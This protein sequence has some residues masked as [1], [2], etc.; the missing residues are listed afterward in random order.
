MKK[1][2]IILASAPGARLANQLW[3]FISIYA[4][5]LAKGYQCQNFS[6]FEE[7]KHKGEKIFNSFFDYG[8]Y[9]NIPLKN[10]F[11]KILLFFHLKN[12]KL[13]RKIRPYHRYVKIIKILHPEKIIYSGDSPFYLPPSENKNQEQAEK[14]KKLELSQDKKI[15]FSGWFLRNP[16]GLAEYRKEIVSY[17]QPKKETQE[18]IAAL[19]DKLKSQY[20]HLVGVHIRQSDYK[21]EFYDGKLYFK[22]KEINIFLKE[23][24]DNFKID[25]GKTCFIICSDENVNLNYFT[26]LNIIKSNFNAVEDLFLL[27]ATDIIIGSDSTFGAFASYYGDI[28]MIVFRRDKIDW[29]YYWDKKRYFENKYLTMVNF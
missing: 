2:I 5:C 8:S 15:Y 27:A 11:L 14:I 6:F 26:D 10:I 21:K 9:F 20:E 17:F 24:L 4:Y 23:Y 13:I 28:P 18:K 1:T 3:N 25:P 16:R 19:T 7:K 29:A 22:E 12:N